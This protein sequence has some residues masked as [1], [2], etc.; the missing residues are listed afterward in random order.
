MG[1]QPCRRALIRGEGLFITRRSG[2]IH[3]HK[4]DDMEAAV[5]FLVWV[6]LST[7]VGALADKRGRNKWRWF[8]ASMV[9]NPLLAWIILYCIRNYAEEGRRGLY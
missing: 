1:V 3:F 2:A 4:E 8:A 7:G 5:W 6:I 9:L